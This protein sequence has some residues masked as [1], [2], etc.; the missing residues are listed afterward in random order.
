MMLIQTYLD[1]STVHGIGVFS[2]EDVKTG[3]VIWQFTP[4]IDVEF[5]EALL[6]TLPEIMQR[7]LMR[8]S[9]PHTENPGFLVLEADNARFMNHSEDT[10]NTDFSAPY[11]GKA[12]KPIRAGDE[13]LCN[14]AGFIPD[15]SDETLRY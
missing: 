15:F 11:I 10:A 3:E 13:L 4:G 9:Y 8:Y 1:K 14:Y 6:S 12:I 2:A 5:S 7:Y